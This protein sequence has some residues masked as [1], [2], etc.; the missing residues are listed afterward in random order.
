MCSTKIFTIALAANFIALNLSA[1]NQLTRS[2]KTEVVNNLAR[3]LLDNYVFADT[4]ISMKNLIQKNL[5]DGL[6]NNIENPNE[7]AQ[8]LNKDLRSIYNDAHLSVTFNPQQ[9]KSLSD[10][11]SNNATENQIQNLQEAKMQN[12][13][14]KKVEIISGNIG[15]VYFDRFY[16]LT[17]NAKATVESVFTFLKN[18][19]AL[20]IDVRNNGGGNPDMVKYICNFLFDKSTHINDL[21]ERRTN[22]TQAY[23]TEP[24]KGSEIFSKIP[25][26]VLTNR[27]TF[28]GAEEFAYDLQSQHRAKIIGETTGGGA[29]LVSPHLIGNG[30]IGLIP[31]ARAINPVTK[32]NWEA[33]GVQPDINIVSDNATDA[34]VLAYYDYKIASLKDTNKIKAIEWSKTILEAKIHPPGVDTLTLKTYTGK[35]GDETFTYN[36][37]ALYMKGRNGKTSRLVALS[38]TTFK[39]EDIDYYKLEFIKNAA[40]QVDQVLVTFNDGYTRTEKRDE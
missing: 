33:V 17:E 12:F 15:Y 13:G 3:S 2:V 29:H 14:F 7:F 31:F 20:I 24:V 28:S 11:S 32:N 18:T 19:D 23:W 25:V 26:Y 9:E 35:F 4:A 22:K 36:N 16:S 21:Y 40:G 30:F 34:A 39:Q 27:R 10:T 38:Q 6:Y 1:Q 8:K 5:A 37:G